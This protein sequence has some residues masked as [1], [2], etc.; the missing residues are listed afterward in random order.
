MKARMMQNYRNLSK[1]DATPC[2]C[3]WLALAALGAGLLTSCASADESPDLDDGG[4]GGST[5]ATTFGTPTSS[6]VTTTTNTSTTASVTSAVTTSGSTTQGASTTG[7]DTSGGPLGGTSTVTSST[8][9]F[10]FGN[11]NTTGSSTTG[12]GGSTSTTGDGGTGGTSTT[13]STTGGGWTPGDPIPKFV[14]NITTGRNSVDTNDRKFSTYWDQITPENAGKWGSVQSNASSD[15][16]WS[17]LDAVYDYAQRTGI[18]FKQHTFVWGSQQPSGNIGEADVK[19]WMREFCQRYPNTPLIDVVNEPPPH[20]TPS[21][22]NAIGGGTNGNWQWIVNS[23]HWAREACPDSILILNDYNNIEWADQNQ[24]FINI[25]KTVINAG[26]PI[27]AVG[28]QAH[29]LTSGVSTDTMKNLLTKLHNDTGLPVYITEYDINLSDDQQHL[30]KFK[31]HL[32]FFLE[33]EWVHGITLWGWIYGSTWVASSGL[34]RNGTPRP[35]M[36]WL[37]EE[38]G[39]PAP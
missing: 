16:N 27:D 33:T 30:N 22:A 25:A 31:E 34:I 23:F 38:L 36:V 32:P 18:L 2:A 11:T 4:I 14:G 12:A 17:T 6:S 28:A 5:G 7:G 15:F 37:M 8:S 29:G 39:R 10:G 24:H 9:G 13:T 21:Y 3:R 26:A 1:L 19:N 20:T 35:A